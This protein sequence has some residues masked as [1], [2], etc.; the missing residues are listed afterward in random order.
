VDESSV[1]FADIGVDHRW[2]VLLLMDVFSKIFWEVFKAELVEYIPSRDDCELVF[3]FAAVDCLE[4]N[5][6]CEP[7]GC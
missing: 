6:L 3:F 5:V 1:E 2:K 4:R 7:T